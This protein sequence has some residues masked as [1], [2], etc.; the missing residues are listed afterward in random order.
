MLVPVLD[1]LLE[2]LSPVDGG[3]AAVASLHEAAGFPSSRF[4]AACFPALDC[5]DGGF[6]GGWR[7]R[8]GGCRGL[9]DGGAVAA[10][11]ASLATA[12]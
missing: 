10:L 8:G 3:G 9:P 4:L 5:G 1:V 11:A 7:G 12:T 2:D 6:L